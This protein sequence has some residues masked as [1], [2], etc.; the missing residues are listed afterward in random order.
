MFTPV[1]KHTILTYGIVIDQESGYKSRT[2]FS[3]DMWGLD[4]N[5]C[6]PT[7]HFAEISMVLVSRGLMGP[8]GLMGSM[9][10]MGPMSMGT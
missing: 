1:V 9:G 5:R 10:H 6:T 7:G 8:I 2:Q 4:I 3:Q